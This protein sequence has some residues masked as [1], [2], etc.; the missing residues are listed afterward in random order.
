M[1]HHEKNGGIPGK[2]KRQGKLCGIGLDLLPV[3]SGT[4]DVNGRKD[5]FLF[6]MKSCLFFI[7]LR[8][9]PKMEG[10]ICGRKSKFCYEVCSSTEVG[11]MYW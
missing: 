6:N 4:T 8:L 5:N 10:A 2:A 9:G 7:S 3:A 1:P 11:F